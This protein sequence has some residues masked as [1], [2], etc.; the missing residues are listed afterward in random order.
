MISG[1]LELALAPEYGANMNEREPSSAKTAKN[2]HPLVSKV[3][4]HMGKLLIAGG[5]VAA[6]AFGSGS[7]KNADAADGW[8]TTTNVC[9]AY[10][11]WKKDGTGL[12]NGVDVEYPKTVTYKLLDDDVAYDGKKSAKLRLPSGTTQTVD[13]LGVGSDA[14]GCLFPL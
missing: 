3:R 2:H 6:T 10:Q 9:V 11:L 7:I 12:F 8:V 5:F 13:F 14:D 1:E 4:E